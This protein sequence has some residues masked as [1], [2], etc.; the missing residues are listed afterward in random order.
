MGSGEVG[1]GTMHRILQRLA[2]IQRLRQDEAQQRLQTARHDLHAHHVELQACHDARDGALRSDASSADELVRR[3]SFSLRQ[4]MLRRRLQATADT[5]ADD[6][7]TRRHELLQAARQVET[8][9]KFADHFLA[10][11]AQRAERRDQRQLDEVG[12]L[13]WRRRG[14]AS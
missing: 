8:T 2:R 11:D 12:L 7:E 6:V 1:T 10:R 5:L 3:H 14:G 9:E 4:E 13:S